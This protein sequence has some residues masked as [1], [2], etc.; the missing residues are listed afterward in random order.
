MR[1]LSSAFSRY[2]VWNQDLNLKTIVSECNSINI[3]LQ[4]TH[5][6]EQ[7]FQISCLEV[8]R[9]HARPKVLGF[10]LAWRI[11]SAHHWGIQHFCTEH[12]GILFS[13]LLIFSVFIFLIIWL[14]FIF[15]NDVYS[16]KVIVLHVGVNYGVKEIIFFIS[17]EHN[18]R[19]FSVWNHAQYL[20]WSETFSYFTTY[21]NAHNLRLWNTI[22]K[23]KNNDHSQGMINCYFL[24]G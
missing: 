10:S 16:I 5:D 22:L 8:K 20:L 12:S 4:S 7:P 23:I 2:Q 9:L 18:H 6:L 3:W 21:W 13:V 15:V 11:V 17:S 19:H 14:N 1:L 24:K